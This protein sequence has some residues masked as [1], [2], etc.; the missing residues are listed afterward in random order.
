[1]RTALV[2]IK[3]KKTSTVW[4]PWCWRGKHSA[5]SSKCIPDTQ[6][7]MIHLVVHIEGIPQ[8]TPT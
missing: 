5:Q 4:T 6:Y 1:M 7:K 3:R 8:I 2:P